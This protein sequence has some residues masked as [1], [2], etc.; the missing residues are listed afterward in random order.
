VRSAA[1]DLKAD[2]YARMPMSLGI[3][4]DIASAKRAHTEVPR[5]PHT[6]ISLQ[7]RGECVQTDRPKSCEEFA[8]TCAGRFGLN[9]PLPFTV[10]FDVWRELCREG[11][12][13]NQVLRESG[14]EGEGGNRSR[15]KD[16]V[17]FCAIGEENG[18]QSRSS[19]R[20]PRRELCWTS[21]S[22]SPESG[23]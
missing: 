3:D 5:A 11:S 7:G 6:R 9:V 18:R 23:A 21:L 17:R 13:R 22:G 15:L 2:V 4:F 20:L 10:A 14:F 1:D 8:A 16:C 19:S 12:P